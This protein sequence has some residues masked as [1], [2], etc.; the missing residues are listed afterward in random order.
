MRRTAFVGDPAERLQEDYQ[1]ILGYF[2]LFGCIATEPDK[3]DD[4]CIEAIKQCRDGLNVSGWS[5]H[6]SLFL[7]PPLNAPVPFED[8]PGEL[9]WAELKKILVG[10]YAYPVLRVM[11]GECNLNKVLGLPMKVNLPEFKRVAEERLRAKGGKLALQPCTALAALLD[12]VD[13]L[14]CFHRRVKLSSMERR[15]ATFLIEN[16]EEVMRKSAEGGEKSA[17]E[18]FKLLQYYVEGTV[19]ECGGKRDEGWAVI[20]PLRQLF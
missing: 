19:H 8:V 11:L 14:E 17:E 3:H 4:V 13:E 1:R 16:R 12:S 6:L 5:I 2:R 20:D 15:L 9:L 7:Q 10:C 18:V